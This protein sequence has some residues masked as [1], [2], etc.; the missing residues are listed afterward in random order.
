[1]KRPRFWLTA[2]AIACLPV[3]ARAQDP[4]EP[5]EEEFIDGPF[6]MD[7]VVRRLKHL[8]EGLPDLPRGNGD[9]NADD[10]I[11]VSDAIYILNWLFREGPEPVPFPCSPPGRELPGDLEPFRGVSLRLEF[12]ETDGEAG[13]SFAADSGE[14]LRSLT[15]H[16][17]ANRRVVDMEAG[18][19]GEL[20]FE[21][22]VLEVDDASLE[23]VRK[24]YPQGDYLFQAVTAKGRHIA[25][26]ANLTHDLLPAPSFRYELGPERLLVQWSRVEG[27]SGYVVEI[28]QEELGFHVTVELEPDSES[29]LVPA[30]FLVGDLEYE[31]GVGT[32]TEAGNLSVA[33]AAFT[34]P[35]SNPASEP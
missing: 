9:V 25:G 15:V 16:D 3:L 32:V 2:L 10:D 8:L 21:E 19:G 35:D 24:A 26:L 6:K 5:A 34:V 17:P 33:E 12:N 13:I 31:L 27:A 18:E 22:V 14:G 7:E 1:M 20:G 29:F 4:V 30:G 28:E 11:N 23:G